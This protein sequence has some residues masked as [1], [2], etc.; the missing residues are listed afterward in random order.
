M[1]WSVRPFVRIVLFYVAGIILGNNL[2][3]FEIHNSLILALCCVFLIAGFAIARWFSSYKFRWFTGVFFLLSMFAFGMFNSSFQKN[4]LS[5]Y[6]D[7]EKIETFIAEVVNDPL[8]TQKAV[9]F[10][11]VANPNNDSLGRKFRVMVYLEKTAKSLNLVYGDKFIFQSK[12]RLFTNAGNPGEFDYGVFLRRKGIVYTTYLNKDQW[13][14]LKYDP[15]NKLIAYAKRL[16][17][18]LL[19]KL[20]EYSYFDGTYEVAAAILLGYDSLM[21]V[22]TEQDF[23]RAGAMHILCVSGLHVGVIF[24]IVSLIL[25][26]LKSTKGGTILRIFLLLIVVWTYALLTGMSPSIQRASVMLSFFILGEA[27]SRL[28][29]SYNTLA[30]SAFLMLLLDPNLIYSV[31][32]QLSYAAVIGIISIYRPVYNLLYFKNRFIDYLWSISAVSIAAQLGTFPIA[33]H[34]F[35]FFPTYF[36]L[37]NLVVI[38]LSFLVIISGFVFLLLS[39]VPYL[40]MATGFIN[41]IFVAGLNE[42]VAFVELLPFHGFDNIHMPL[43]KLVLV[44][45]IIFISFQILLLRKIIYLKYLISIVV[46]MIAFN[47]VVKLRNQSQNSVIVFNVNKHDVIEFV[48]G[49]NVIRLA[50][51]AF[52]NDDKISDFILKSNHINKGLKTKY[53]LNL[54]EHHQFEDDDLFVNGGF[55]EYLN[56]KY[57]LLS[58]N[59]SLFTSNNSKPKFDAIIIS[60]KRRFDM[61]KLIEC[62]NFKK[63][64][65]SS[66]V[67]FWKQTQIVNDCKINGIEFFNVNTDGAYVGER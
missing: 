52:N 43:P 10:E 21:D 5:T 20:K 55:V 18:K 29:D 1:Q 62:M 63:I 47:T 34:Y 37:V 4:N 58:S 50:D 53:V 61:N 6:G 41:S 38:P 16:R 3:E 42:I 17:E 36:W 45:L 19:K 15:S 31:G 57:F 32:F 60:G 11:I 13:R 51:S 44:Y 33:T 30:A 26:F 65:I 67:P 54:E 2:S 12:L 40:S 66:S 39:W 9:K 46:L 8:Q 64:I 27:F 22:E 59:D 49:E 24:M 7:F 25:N 56:R 28:K 14:Y 35:H 48:K 23:V